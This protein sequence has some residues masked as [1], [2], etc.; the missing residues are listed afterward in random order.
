MLMSSRFRKDLKTLSMFRGTA[1]WI[2][3]EDLRPIEKVVMGMSVSNPSIPVVRW[4][5][6]PRKA[7][8][9]PDLTTWVCSAEHRETV[10][11]KSNL[12]THGCP[13]TSHM[14]AC[15]HKYILRI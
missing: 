7:W 1:Q 2:Q 13:L 9:L 12:D 11:A 15:M 8:Q 4:K 3:C 6:E 5:M 14:H 10:S